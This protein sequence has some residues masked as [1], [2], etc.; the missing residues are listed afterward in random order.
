MT[1]IG[2]VSNL[3]LPPPPDPVD[4]SVFTSSVLSGSLSVESVTITM[5]MF[6]A[7]VAVS[8]GVV[9]GL[10]GVEGT[11]DS[12]VVGMTLESKT[13]EAKCRFDTMR[14]TKGKRRLDGDVNISEAQFRTVARAPWKVTML[15]T[16]PSP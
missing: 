2:I 3:D 5:G 6:S 8:S 4:I 16:R 9:V 7:G 11:P 10:I 13:A 15:S 12:V 14:K 1:G